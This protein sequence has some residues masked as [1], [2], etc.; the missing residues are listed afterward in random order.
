MT[1]TFAGAFLS[2]GVSRA[3]SDVELI[4]MVFGCPL[5]TDAVFRIFTT[6]LGFA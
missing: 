2:D 5:D 1:I 3:F 4:L 6:E